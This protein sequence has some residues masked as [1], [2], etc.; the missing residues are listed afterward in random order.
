[1]LLATPLF[2]GPCAFGKNFSARIKVRSVSSLV[3]GLSRLRLSAGRWGLACGAPAVLLLHLKSF[4]RPAGSYESSWTARLQ[5]LLA[6]FLSS[7]LRAFKH[8]LNSA[9]SSGLRVLVNLRLARL[10][11]ASSSLARG[12]QSSLA[13]A[14]GL[15]YGQHC[16]SRSTSAPWRLLRGSGAS[17]QG[18]SFR[19]S[20]NR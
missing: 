17:A 12:D 7:R 6:F 4:Q 3:N 19:W 8:A 11:P 16:G 10:A 18:C 20:L 5:L 9:A 2:L 15:A 1:M 14:C 13:R